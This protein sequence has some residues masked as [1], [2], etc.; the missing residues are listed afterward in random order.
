MRIIEAKEGGEEVSNG[1][2][3][4]KEGL[5]AKDFNP[6][7]NI[8]EWQDYK[9]SLYT[10]DPTWNPTNPVFRE[11]GPLHQGCYVCIAEVKPRCS[12]PVFERDR[13]RDD[14]VNRDM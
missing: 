12:G 14:G 5:K 3:E 4:A 6:L 8:E 10:E 2:K 11:K 7:G 13:L 9:E 1:L